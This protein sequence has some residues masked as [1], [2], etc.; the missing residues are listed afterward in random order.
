MIEPRYLTLDKLL[1]ELLADRLFRTPTTSGLIVWRPG[2]GE[3][4]EA[5]DLNRLALP[6]VL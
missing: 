6:G 3:R 5:D 1:A 4:E 2:S